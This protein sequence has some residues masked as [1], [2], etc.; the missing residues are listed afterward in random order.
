MLKL[1]KY[2]F[3]FFVLVILSVI[4]INV[5][6]SQNEK[7]A[8]EDRAIASKQAATRAAEK[9]AKAEEQAKK[10]AE[11]KALEEQAKK[12]VLAALMDAFDPT[13]PGWGSFEVR[14]A[15]LTG[16]GQVAVTLV[17]SEKPSGYRQVEQ[18]TT[19]V[20][21]A[22]LAWLVSQGKEPAKQWISVIAS[23]QMREAGETGQA[24]VRI[25]GRSSYDFNNDQISF[26][27]D[28]NLW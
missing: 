18:D 25:F 22:V 23:A 14:Q 11:E 26:T 4:A 28:T 24:L 15:D 19:K 27:K 8:I 12:D 5:V 2:L 3:R 21:R 16:I 7:Q 13:P 20:V 6:I 17:Y 10:D 9:A 1:L